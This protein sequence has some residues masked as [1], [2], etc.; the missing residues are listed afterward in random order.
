MDKDK[1][2][3]SPADMDKPISKSSLSEDN[4]QVSNTLSLIAAAKHAVLWVMIKDIGIS[5]FWYQYVYYPKL[6]ICPM[7]GINFFLWYHH[8]PPVI[9]DDIKD[10]RQNHITKIKMMPT[11][12]S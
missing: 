6:S 5:D 8:H 12:S 11:L 1:V 9:G 10:M 7:I 3:D 2:D 4:V